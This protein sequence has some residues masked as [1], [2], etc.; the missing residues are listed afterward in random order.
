[1]ETSRHA[2]FGTRIVPGR[3][4]L[5][6]NY[7]TYERIVTFRLVSTP[8]TVAQYSSSPS[9]FSYKMDKRQKPGNLQR[10]EASF[11]CSGTFKFFHILCC[12]LQIV[13]ARLSMVERA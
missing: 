8:S 7:I 5:S 9:C 3:E 1:M 4:I 13:D 10:K 2:A 11:E 12:S 6:K